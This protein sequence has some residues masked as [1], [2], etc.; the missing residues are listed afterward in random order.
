MILLTPFNTEM[1]KNILISTLPAPA[2]GM[3]LE[4][5]N[6]SIVDLKY[7]LLPKNDLIDA[8]QHRDGEEYPKQYSSCSSRGC[9]WNT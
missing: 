4:H 2:W 1:A 3:R 7:C 9:A 8:L 5:L 6:S